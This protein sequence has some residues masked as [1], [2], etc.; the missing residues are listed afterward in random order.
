LRGDESL[1]EADVR[2]LM[3]A[4][5]ALRARRARSDSNGSNAGGNGYSNG[6]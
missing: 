6:G 3:Q 4:Y 5:I 1:T 2:E